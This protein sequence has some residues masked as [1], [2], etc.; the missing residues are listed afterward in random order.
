MSAK[1][2]G[3]VFDEGRRFLVIEGDGSTV[4]IKVAGLQATFELNISASQAREI[5]RHLMAAAERPAPP[6]ARRA[7]WHY[8]SQGYCDNPGRGY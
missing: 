8:D 1:Y 4:T 2:H 7:D 5:G 6:C 3:E